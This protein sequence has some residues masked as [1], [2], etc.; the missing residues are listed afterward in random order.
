MTYRPF[1]YG[2]SLRSAA[3]GR[4]L[5]RFFDDVFPTAVHAVDRTS[6]KAGTA[7][8]DWTPVVEAKE[9]DAGYSFDMEI[10]G[11]SPESVEVLALDGVLTIRGSKPAKEASEGERVLL[12]ERRDGRFERTF[13]LPKEADLNQVTASY[14]LGV[15]T[16]QVAK[17]AP[18]QAVRVPVSV[19]DSAKV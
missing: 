12:N 17:A 14:R 11:V 3:F 18:A 4:D 1:I 6:D 13:R 7:P 5:Q 16:V 15:L 19:Q 9:T 10:P 8:P 2:P